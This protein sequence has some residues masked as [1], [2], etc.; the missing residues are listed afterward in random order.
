[1][2]D[3]E[4]S[5]IVRAKESERKRTAP[6]NDPNLSPSVYQAIYQLEH[7]NMSTQIHLKIIFFPPLTSN[8]DSNPA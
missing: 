3:A 6:R 7:I 5:I 8:P 1:M 2:K 4:L